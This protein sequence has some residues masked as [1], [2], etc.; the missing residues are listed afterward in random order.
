MNYDHLTITNYANM[1]KLGMSIYAA[2]FGHLYSRSKEFTTHDVGPRGQ[3]PSQAVPYI[4]P[5]T[6]T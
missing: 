1:H 5:D 3:P 2:V 6:T 4:L